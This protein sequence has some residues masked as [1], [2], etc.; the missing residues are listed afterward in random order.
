MSAFGLWVAVIAALLGGCTE[1]SGNL[2]GGRGSPTPVLTTVS[3]SKE[4]AV[5]TDATVYVLKESD[6]SFDAYATATFR[7][8]FGRAVYFQRC[9]GDSQGPMYEIRRTGIQA[10]HRSLVGAVWA[11]VGGVSTGDVPHGESIS[12]R[13]WLGSAKSPNANPPDRPEDRVGVFRILL[14]LCRTYQGDSDDC[15][16]LPDSERRSNEFEIRY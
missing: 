16:L 3:T 7:N 6:G 9:T 8:H 4:D 14:N 10:G 13:V 15:E 2:S 1:S 5:K 11:C 12:V